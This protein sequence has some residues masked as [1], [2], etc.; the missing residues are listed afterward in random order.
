MSAHVLYATQDALPLASG[1]AGLLGQALARFDLAL[2]SDG[3]DSAGAFVFR[4]AR[5]RLTLALHPF[6]CPAEDLASALDAPFLAVKA[7]GLPEQVAAHGAHLRLDLTA[8]AAPAKPLPWHLRLVVLHRALLALAELSPPVALHM[9]LSDMLF[10][11]DELEQTRTAT[12]PMQLCLHPLPVA[13]A[14][15]PEIAGIL[16]PLGL[17]VAGAERFCGKPLILAPSGLPLTEGAALVARLLRDHASG[18]APLEDGAVLQDAQHGA[19]YLR[20][21]PPDEGASKGRILVGLGQAPDDS[22]L[23]AKPLSAAD[24]RPAPLKRGKGRV[25]GA[26]GGLAAEALRLV[27]SPN[28]LLVIGGVI[29][30]VVISHMAANW[31][32]AQNAALGFSDEMFKAGATR[33]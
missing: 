27:L 19:V 4:G 15:V 22:V 9:G 32:D 11:A 5:F 26:G 17:V 28:G 14:D 7:P 31:V 33:P 6:P 1:F 13:A 20:H 25:A 18:K 21:G 12:L 2:E 16:P 3:A 24:L 23:R 29:A 10:D 30:F 8:P